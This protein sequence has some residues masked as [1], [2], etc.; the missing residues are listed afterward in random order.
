MNEMEQG[1]TE[2]LV[3][4]EQDEHAEQTA[5]HCAP[6]VTDPFR[7]VIATGD[8]SE[9]RGRSRTRGPAGAGG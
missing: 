6:L 3:T 4:Y 5:A 1:L 8:V 7:E 2:I 9:W